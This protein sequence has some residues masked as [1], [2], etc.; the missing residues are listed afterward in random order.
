M[1]TIA[2]EWRPIPGYKDY[3]VSSS[4]RVRSIDRIV[5]SIR[6]N[7]PTD[8][9]YK[10]R[11]L[12]LNDSRGYFTVCVDGARRSHGVH[13]L[14][15]FAFIGPCPDGMQVDH[16]NGDRRD[17]RP[18]NL[19]YV[20]PFENIRRAKATRAARGVAEASRIRLDPAKVVL[21]R[22]LSKRLSVLD[23]SRE[24][25]ISKQHVRR[26]L[27]HDSWKHVPHITSTTETTE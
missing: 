8:V 9:F 18:E 4:G 23:L 6:N 13:R 22:N 25:G 16:I 15:A 10:G 7:T 24:F 5:R 2:D 21:L 1:E 20:S 12:K 26:V 3:E 19:E 17:N 27:A 14:V 11:I